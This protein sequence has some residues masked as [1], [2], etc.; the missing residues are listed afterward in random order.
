MAQK[1]LS[2]I[3]TVPKS[4][5]TSNLSA[6]SNDSHPHDGDSSQERQGRSQ[7]Q[8]LQKLRVT[9]DG[10]NPPPETLLQ[11]LEPPQFPSQRNA[12]NPP[13]SYGS[14]PGSRVG[15]PI[16]SRDGSRSRP[17]T[18]VL[19]GPGGIA[20]SPQR[21]GTPGSAKLNKRRS[22]MPGSGGKSEKS[23]IDQVSHEPKAWIAGL[24]E[25]IPYDITPLINGMRVRFSASQMRPRS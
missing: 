1:R 18:P 21:P 4:R 10:S 16:N 2:S 5:S 6:A 19:L 12:S 3:F 8:K 24:R 14:G 17:Q 22:W 20:Q 25:H 7:Q 11:D 13:S 15:S 23:Q 9:S